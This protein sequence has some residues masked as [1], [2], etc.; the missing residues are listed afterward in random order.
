MKNEIENKLEEKVKKTE[1][2]YSLAMEWPEDLSK[3]IVL[4]IPCRNFEYFEDDLLDDIL[5]MV[6]PDDVDEIFITQDM[7]KIA[8]DSLA[9]IFIDIVSPEAKGAS[10]DEIKQFIDI[11]EAD[12]ETDHFVV[13]CIDTSAKDKGKYRAMYEGKMRVIEK[14]FHIDLDSVE[15]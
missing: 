14:K 15:L 10:E 9:R 11:C 8:K 12:P 7:D 6:V 3:S 1:E 4:Y 5:Q 2:N 13:A